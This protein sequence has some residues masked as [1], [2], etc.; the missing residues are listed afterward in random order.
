M[1]PV[2]SAKWSTTRCLGAPHT[3]RVAPLTASHDLRNHIVD[4]IKRAKPGETRTGTHL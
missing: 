3:R 4:L 1:Y 2:V